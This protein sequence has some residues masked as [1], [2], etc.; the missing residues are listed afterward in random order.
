MTGEASRMF[1]G[2]GSRPPRWRRGKVMLSSVRV[3]VS[4]QLFIILAGLIITGCTEAQTKGQPAGKTS[5]P[6]TVRAEPAVEESVKRS[7]DV[8]ATLAA[9]DEVIVSSEADGV[10]RRILADLG[11][12][13]TE[14]QVLV[15]LDREK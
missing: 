9:A 4:G 8:V 14:G 3:A 5:A 15:E 13:V 6:R 12:R 10:V 7:L 11:D 1:K 2:S